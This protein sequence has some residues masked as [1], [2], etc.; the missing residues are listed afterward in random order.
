MNLAGASCSLSICPRFG[1][2]VT[3][4]P[5]DGGCNKLDRTSSAASQS[6]NALAVAYL[7]KLQ[8]APAPAARCTWTTH[9]RFLH[10]AVERRS[11][12]AAHR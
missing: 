11:S 6:A 12:Y 5:R 8:H 10:H 7:F 2:L 1:I 3:A 4:V 9:C